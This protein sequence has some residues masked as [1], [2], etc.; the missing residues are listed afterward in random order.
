LDE[1]LLFEDLG[2]LRLAIPVAAML[3]ALMLADVYG[4]RAKPAVGPVLAFGCAFLPG[5]LPMRITLAAGAM[6]LLLVTGLRML[7]GRG[8]W[9]PTIGAYWQNQVLAPLKVPRYVATYLL[10]GLAIGA[11]CL[12]FRK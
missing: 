3:V 2:L 11:I 8:D 5:A 9:T 12:L 1:P 6:S 4:N 10:V 7:F